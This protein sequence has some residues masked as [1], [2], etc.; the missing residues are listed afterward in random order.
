MSR[1]WGWDILRGLCALAVATYHLM[2]WQALGSLHAFGSYGVYLFFVLSGASLAY[3]Y[4]GQL[5]SARA[6]MG[7]LAT[8]WL[9]LAPLYALV[10]LACI[11]L[12]SLH[13]GALVDQLPLRLLLNLTFAFGVHDPV[14]WALPIGGWSLGIEFAYYLLFPWLLCAVAHPVTRWVLLAALCGAQASWIASTA[15]SAAGYTA[16]QVAYHQLPAFGAYFFAG[17]LIGQWQRETPQ[18]LPVAVGALVWL[19]LG[20][21]LWGL[22]PVLP[23]NELLG[24]RGLVLFG[25]CLAVV[26]LSGWTRVPQGLQPLARWL[27]DI[28]Y[29]T[30]L[31]HPVLFFGFTWF[32]LPV[33][34]ATPVNELAVSVRWAL[35]GST[36]TV[37]CIAAAAS[38]RWLESPLRHWGQQMLARR[39]RFPAKG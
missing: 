26:V 12:Y 20:G 29:G 27:G 33:L 10:T 3:N 21:L 17:C 38:A 15:G 6:A 32:A 36:L 5:G 11:V 39:L 4:S 18:T 2:E 13:F 25:A 1:I 14:V 24:V 37:A 9:R 34:T 8:R 16:S 35:L 23:G 7:F 28:T 19:A 30:Y 31:L 22:N